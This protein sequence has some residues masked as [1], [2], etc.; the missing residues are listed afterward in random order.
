MVLDTVSS[1]LTLGYNLAKV[2]NGCF[3]EFKTHEQEESEMWYIQRTNVILASDRYIRLYIIYRGS[4]EDLRKDHPHAWE[5]MKQI[6]T[7]AYDS[8]RLKKV[9]FVQ[10][11]SRTVSEGETENQTKMLDDHTVG[12]A[13]HQLSDS[14]LASIIASKMNIWESHGKTNNM[15]PYRSVA[16]EDQTD[17]AV[18]THQ[19]PQNS[20]VPH[21]GG[22]ERTGDAMF[23]SHFENTSSGPPSYTSQPASQPSSLTLTQAGSVLIAQTTKESIQSSNSQTELLTEVKKLRLTQTQVLHELKEQRKVQEE[24]AKN[25]GRTANNTEGLA[26]GMEEM[27]QTA[28]ETNDTLV[29]VN[30]N[31]EQ[32]DNS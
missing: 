25:T 11:T 27:R 32:P 7:R 12:I 22:R 28:N 31:E 8:N 14:Q 6:R 16:P 17:E 9:V 21:L 20:P 26:E 23:L 29:R 2:E 5:V 15:T 3:E 18:S 19:S 30:V 13:E 1:D 24:T 4:P 10:V